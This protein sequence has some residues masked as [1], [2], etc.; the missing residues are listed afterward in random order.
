MPLPWTPCAQTLAPEPR[1]PGRVLEE[2]RGG[3]A[4]ASLATQSDPSKDGRNAER[5]RRHSQKRREAAGLNRH[6][7]IEAED[8][9]V[10]DECHH[11]ADGSDH[12]R[13][14]LTAS[15]AEPYDSDV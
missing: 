2:L 15:Q 13:P 10:V 5:D 8:R 9:Q 3:A 6:A 14:P 1:P 11:A 4:G 7:C 12:E